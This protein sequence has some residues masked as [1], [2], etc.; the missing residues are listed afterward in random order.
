MAGM[1]IMLVDVVEVV[2]VVAVVSIGAI[3]VITVMMVNVAGTVADFLD[4][5]GFIDWLIEVNR[6]FDHM[7]VLEDRRIKLVSYRLRGGASAWWERL[8]EDRCRE[9]KAKVLTSEKMQRIGVQQ[10]VLNLTDT[11]NL[12]LK[13][14][15]L[16][17]D[18]KWQSR[19]SRWPIG[20]MEKSKWKQGGE[21]SR[22]EKGVTEKAV[23]KKA[24]EPKTV[25]SSNP[26]AKLIL[27][28]CF[29][30]NQPGHCSGDCSRRRQLVIVEWDADSCPDDE[31]EICCESEES[32]EE[33]QWHKLFRIKCAVNGKRCDIVIDG[34]SEEN[35]ISRSLI[36]KLHLTVKKHSHPYI[37][38]WIREVGGIK[39]P[40]RCKVPFSIGQYKVELVKDGVKY[41]LTSKKSNQPE[42]SK[43]EGKT[44]VTLTQS[45]RE[46]EEEVKESG[47]IYVLVV[48]DIVYTKESSAVIPEVVRPV[49]EEFSDIL[50]KELPD[51]L[52]PM[53][54]DMLD[55]L[56]GSNVFSKIDLRS[57]YYQI[58]IRP[59][60]EWKIV[61]KTRDGLFEWLVMPFG[62]SNAPSTF[63]RLMNQEEKFHWGEE[64][65]ATFALIKEK[66]CTAPILAL[67]DFGKLFEVEC[68]V[69]DLEIGAVLSQE[70][71]PVAFFSEKLN[72]ARR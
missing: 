36:D 58:R 26:Y 47:E 9:R 59:G 13:A 49:L 32:D 12:A 65:E 27:G 72:D 44:L 67:L 2:V 17:Q 30:Y 8:Q 29:K 69:S 51:G 4:I 39:V 6:F 15:T 11:R 7:D 25:K 52:P 42:A 66:L 50:P 53:L 24:V 68:D 1:G 28:K 61:F 55:Q 34:G 56:S 46:M 54:D 70:K 33:R 16:M 60:D 5:E 41:T 43:A 23:G 45:L 63:M 10:M 40:E 38:G 62:L 20:K 21:S 64:A 18:K 35:F 19:K 22:E 3:N 57:G 48:K 31:G 37:I 71:R 14:E